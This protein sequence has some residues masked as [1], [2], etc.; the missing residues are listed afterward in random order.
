MPAGWPTYI[1]STMYFSW[2]ISWY[3]SWGSPLHRLGLFGAGSY[4]WL[5]L[6]QTTAL[7]HYIRRGT[8][9]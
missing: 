7:C 8:A 9:C 2:Y 6:A 4:A 1:F 3:F 5:C